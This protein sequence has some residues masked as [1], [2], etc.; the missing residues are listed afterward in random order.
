VIDEHEQNPIY[1]APGESPAT[2]RAVA[3]IGLPELSGAGDQVKRAEAVRARLLVDADDV[4]TRL[5]S[6]EIITEAQVDTA[7]VSPRQVSDD[8]VHAAEAALNRLRRVQDAAW[9]IEH[10]SR[11][12]GDILAEFMLSPVQP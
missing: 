5:R 3:E 6:D 10:G 9:W 4:M 1:Q 12:A 11:S 8:Q 7:I 2:R